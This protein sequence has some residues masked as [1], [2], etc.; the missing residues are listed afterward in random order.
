MASLPLPILAIGG[1]VALLIT[2]KKTRRRTLTPTPNNPYPDEG[3]DYLPRAMD[4][5]KELEGYETSAYRDSVGIPTIGYGNTTYPDGSRVRMGDTITQEEALLAA[6]HFVT[7]KVIPMLSSKI[8]AW[9]QFNENQKAAIISFTY[10]LGP[11]FFG[12]KNFKSITAALLSPDYVNA[13]PKAL[14]LYIYADGKILQG[15]INRRNAE[16]KVWNG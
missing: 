3:Q 10:N 13:V 1:A 12:A 11:H 6:E 8:P 9:A 2:A 16:I 4:L 14:K 5:I 7:T 15:L